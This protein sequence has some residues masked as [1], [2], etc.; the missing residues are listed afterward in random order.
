MTTVI[1]AMSDN[2]IDDYLRRIDKLNFP[3]GV[4][5]LDHGWAINSVKFDFGLPRP[6]KTK[7]KI[8]PSTV[9][10]IENAGFIPGLWFAP[11][12]LYPKSQLFKEFPELRG[13][14]FT[15]A[16]E[17]GFNFPLHYLEG[18]D[19]TDNIIY[20]W[21]KKM[22]TP[23]IEMG[24]RKL[25]ID[26]TYNNKSKM[27]KILELLYRAVKDINSEVEIEGHIPDIFA[28]QY[29][30]AVRLN[31]LV[32][33]TNPEWESLFEDHYKVC[34]N[35][36]YKT[37]L[38]LDYVGTNSSSISEADFLKSLAQFKG[39][40]GYPVISMLPDHFSS[41]AIDAVYEYLWEYQAVNNLQ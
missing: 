7:F 22:F 20:N 34:L 24:I 33:E 21:Y 15:G 14:K 12:F 28:S 10:R 23:Y 16:N 19:E 3:R 30:D 17:G 37:Q 5:T 26:F 25:K 18:T 31:D 8:F 32:I 39:K 2:F 27:I 13:E 40:T 4:L 1:N 35:S 36:A 9:K 29:Q 11:A 6:D 38:N 41:K